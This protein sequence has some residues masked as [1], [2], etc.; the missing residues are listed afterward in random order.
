MTVSYH[1]THAAATDNTENFFFFYPDPDRVS[2][3]FVKFPLSSKK[4]IFTSY[5]FMYC[6]QLDL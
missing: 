5:H 6:I 3:F 4:L 1:W 2:N